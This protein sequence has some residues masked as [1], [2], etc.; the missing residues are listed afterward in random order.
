MT[1][2]KTYL[3]ILNKVKLPIILFTTLLIFFGGL[4]IFDDNN[5]VNFSPTKPKVFII[6]N[7]EKIGVTKNL[8]DYIK[9]NSTISSIKNT[10]ESINDALFYRDINYVIYIPKNYRKDFLNNKNPEIKVKS[11]GTYQASLAEMI[12]ERYLKVSN[13]YNN[14]ISDEEE[15]IKNINNTLAKNTEVELTSKL[16]VSKMSTVVF[17]YNF[18]NYSVLAGSIYVVCL[19]LSIFNDEKIRKRTLISSMNYKEFN[20]KLLIAN[21]LFIIVL[22]LFYVI[23]SYIL[24]GNIILTTHGLFYILN[25]LIFTLCSLA[26]A[27][28]ISTLIKDKNTINGIINVVALGSSFLCGSFVPIEF[29]PDVVLKIARF[30]PSY[31]YIRTNEILKGIQIFNFETLKPVIFNSF[32][33]V[34]FGIIFIIIINIVLNK[35]RKIN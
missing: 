5:H 26:M 34:I 28:L 1:V 23:L 12:L 29:L 3:K 17:Y 25:S 35:K 11:S 4:N 20:T 27:F 33:L 6:N 2:F 30:L 8:I 18:L 31:Y 22:W 10:E 32:M 7:D 19:I 13:A 15:I 16:D 9:E 14:K 24:I 21:S